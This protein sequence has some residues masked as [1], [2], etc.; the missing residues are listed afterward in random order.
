MII[1]LN[2]SEYKE[3]FGKLVTDITPHSVGTY[4]LKWLTVGIPPRPCLSTEEKPRAPELTLTDPRIDPAL[5]SCPTFL[6]TRVPCAV[7]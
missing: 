2:L 6:R 3:G 7:P 1:D 4:E 5:P